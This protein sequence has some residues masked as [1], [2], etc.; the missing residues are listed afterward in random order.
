MNPRVSSSLYLGFA[1]L[2]LLPLVSAIDILRPEGSLTYRE[3]IIDV[4][5]TGN[6]TGT[7]TCYYSFGTGASYRIENCDNISLE[8]PINTGHLNLTL[9]EANDTH[10]ETDKV[11]VWINNDFTTAK[12]ILLGFLLIVFLVLPFIF[13]YP[14][15]KLDSLH[16]PIKFFLTMLGF[17]S[18]LVFLFI[19]QALTASYIHNTILTSVLDTFVYAY[20]WI[21]YV[22]ITYFII[23]FLFSLFELW[24]FRRR[25]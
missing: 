3:S 7:T 9:T 22:I 19:S 11:E 20:T 15:F 10:A 5:Y 2:L 12:G 21:F 25:R 1:L 23:T 24:K 16:T 6:L 14:C 8:F 13:W 18:G 4:N 17:F